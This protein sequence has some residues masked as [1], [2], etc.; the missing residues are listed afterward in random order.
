MIFKT[1]GEQKMKRI[2]LKKRNIAV[3]TSLFALVAVFGPA[4]VSA[5]EHG[6]AKLAK[7]TL[8]FGWA[9]ATNVF[10]F[11]V[12]CVPH[13]SS[14]SLRVEQGER[15][16]LNKVLFPVEVCGNWAYMGDNSLTANTKYKVTAQ[17]IGD[18]INYR[19]SE[20]SNEI[21]ASTK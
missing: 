3:L 20:E 6:G 19:T 18:G 14:Y 9:H 21:R 2:I 12:S 1:Q 7:P 5:S 16:I 11:S 10:T 13:A 17:A 15:T 8:T 4:P